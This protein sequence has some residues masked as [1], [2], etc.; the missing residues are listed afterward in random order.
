MVT[1]A[2]AGPLKGEPLMSTSTIKE[3][4]MEAERLV[5]IID[6]VEQFLP[7]ERYQWRKL[8]PQQEW[9]PAAVPGC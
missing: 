6:Q 5:L 4:A 7:V 2:S 8:L 1:G 3:T 9:C